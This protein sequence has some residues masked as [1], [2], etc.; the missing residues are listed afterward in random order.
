MPRSSTVQADYEF[1]VL[2][3][4]EAA[5]AL[6]RRAIEMKPGEPQYRINRAK[7]LIALGREREA[8][9]DIAYLRGMGVGDNEEAALALEKRIPDRQARQ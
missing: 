9:E 6:W 5:L 2:R 4:E 1:N 7:V 8:R 3:H